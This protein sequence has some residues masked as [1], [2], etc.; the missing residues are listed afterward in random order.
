MDLQQHIGI[1]I[2]DAQCCWQADHCPFDNICCTALN[3]GINGLSFGKGA[4]SLIFILDLRN[5]NAPAKQ[6]FDIMIYFGKLLGLIHIGAD[7]GK[8]LKIGFDIIACLALR[9]RKLAR[10]TKAGNAVNNTKINRFGPASG[11]CV[12]RL[13][14]DIEN[15]CCGLGMNIHPLVKGSYHAFLACYM[16]NQPQFNLAVIGGN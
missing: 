4:H 9:N 5:M 12:H 1:N 8:T 6:G 2:F 7:T 14:R 15:L 16:G 13:Q 10:Q 11:F 3:R